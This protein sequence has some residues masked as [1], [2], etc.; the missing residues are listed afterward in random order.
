MLIRFS[1]LL[2][3]NKDDIYENLSKTKKDG[4]KAKAE[5]KSGSVR[6]R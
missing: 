5:K 3:R 2:N 6:K 1:L 4:K